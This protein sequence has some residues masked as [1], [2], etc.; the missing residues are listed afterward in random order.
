M[1][2]KKK[3]DAPLSDMLTAK[4]AA[5]RL[6]FTVRGLYALRRRG[7]GPPAIR[8]GSELRFSA[9]ELDDWMRGQRA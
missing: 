6:R 1:T 4:E 2:T 5:D 8:I 9:R 3:L 7:D